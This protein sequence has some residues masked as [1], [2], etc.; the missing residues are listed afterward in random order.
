MRC[1]HTPFRIKAHI[2]WTA[3]TENVGSSKCEW[4]K[5]CKKSEMLHPYIAEEGEAIHSAFS[6]QLKELVAAG[7]LVPSELATKIVIE[8]MESDMHA[9]TFGWLLDGFPRTADQ[10]NA[11]NAAQHIPDIL[12]L[13][14]VPDEEVVKRVINR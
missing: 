2:F 14:D 6:A 9:K 1:N 7:E 13:L 4:C 12:I 8:E 11:L 3:L 10:V 5:W